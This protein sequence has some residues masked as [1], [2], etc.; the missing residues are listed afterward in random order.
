MVLALV[1]SV[2]LLNVGCAKTAPVRLPVVFSDHMV[3]QRGMDVPVWGWSEPGAHVTV[4]MGSAK[5]VTTATDEGAFLVCLPPQEA[6]GPHTITVTSEN[7]I[8][9]KD[10][11]VGDV[12]ICSGQSNMAMA[13]NRVRDAEKEIARAN[14]PDIRLFTVKRT[15]ATKPK[16]DVEGS[17]VACSPETVPGF[18]AVGYFF[19]RALDEH[20][21]VPI[22]LVNTS[23]GGTPSEAWTSPGTIAK[24]D[25]FDPIVKRWQEQVVTYAERK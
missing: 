25:A 7:T 9:V 21:K 15:P 17:W 10:V 8:W 5:A 19:G 22:G 3:V 18:S 16:D 4:Q 2:V 6:G 11:L 12:W 24:T 23:W 20:L 14:F 1:L 13:V